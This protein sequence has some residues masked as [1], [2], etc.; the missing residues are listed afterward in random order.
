[1]S[2]NNCKR[3]LLRS[4]IFNNELGQRGRRPLLLKCIYWIS[5]RFRSCSWRKFISDRGDLR[6]GIGWKWKVETSLS[7][8]VSGILCRNMWEGGTGRCAAATHFLSTGR[9]FCMVFAIF[10][11][12]RAG[13]V[14]AIAKEEIS[15]KDVASIMEPTRCR[16][17]DHVAPNQ[18]FRRH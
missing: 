1:M 4:K 8:Q 5:G 14:F 15:R 2:K 6:G 17:T 7:P 13:N 9:W 18:E 16:W 12:R 11:Q 10:L 3:K